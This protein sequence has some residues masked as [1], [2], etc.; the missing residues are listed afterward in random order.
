MSVIDEERLKDRARGLKDLGLNGIEFVI[1]TLKEAP[2]HS[3]AYLELHFYNNNELDNML[4]ESA[5]NLVNIFPI[6]GGTRILAGPSPGQVKVK[7]VEGN[8]GQSFLRLVVSPVGDYSTYQL[9]VSYKNI[10][11]HLSFSRINFKFRP[12]CFNIDCRP[13]WEAVT[14][15][16]KEP[17]I[18]YLVKD[19]DSF[20]HTMISSMMQR[21][22][23]W[24]PTSEADQDMVLLEL[25]SAGADELSDYQDRVMNEA[26][27][28]TAKKRVSLARHARLINYFIYQGNQAHTYLALNVSQ[29]FEMDGILEVWTGSTI[30]DHFSIVFSGPPSILFNKQDGNH[31]N[32]N[33]PTFYPEL[34]NIKLYTWSDS[35]IG[36]KAGTRSADLIL[37]KVDGLTD[38]TLSEV[39]VFQDLINQGLILHLL[40]QA[41][42]PSE[43]QS[44]NQESYRLKDKRQLLSLTKAR[45]IFDP[46][47]TKN[48]LRVWWK[49]NLNFDICT[50]YR[51][52]PWK[53]TPSISRREDAHD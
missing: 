20:K 28:L 34:N 24:L 17:V 10:D 38:L 35:V 43:P 9:S 49:E 21:V 29:K 25:L 27:L 41:G 22:P 2:I 7:E 31:Q 37:K 33:N 15:T 46:A 48:V 5:Q 51:S 4:A 23:G 3:E 19:Y 36:L 8:P 12:G 45:V 42:H 44:Q 14:Q 1:V 26:Y 32:N 11:P 13:E 40:I 39:A 16:D 52:L 30:K 50:E 18:D 6:S 53:R 47:T